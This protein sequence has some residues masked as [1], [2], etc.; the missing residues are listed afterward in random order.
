[1]KQTGRS[2]SGTPLAREQQKDIVELLRHAAGSLT[3]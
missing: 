1:M 3:P 2:G